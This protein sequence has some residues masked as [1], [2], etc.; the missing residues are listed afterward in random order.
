MHIEGG[1]ESTVLAFL[2]VEKGPLFLMRRKII[3][4]DLES[5]VC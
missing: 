5:P 1:W 3:Q 4:I 2:S